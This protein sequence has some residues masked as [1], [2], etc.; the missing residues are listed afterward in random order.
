MGRNITPGT[1]WENAR[2]LVC[3]SM[4]GYALVDVA[5]QA[6]VL[7]KPESADT[8]LQYLQVKAWIAE[9]A[10]VQFPMQCVLDELD[11]HLGGDTFA[12]QMMNGQIR[13]S[14]GDT[15]ALFHWS[16]HVDVRFTQRKAQKGQ[17]AAR[18]QQ[19]LVQQTQATAARQSQVNAAR[20]RA[21]ADAVT[22]TSRQRRS[23]QRYTAAGGF[24]PPELMPVFRESRAQSVPEVLARQRLSDERCAFCDGPV[25][26]GLNWQEECAE[27]PNFRPAV[28]GN[29]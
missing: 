7:W 28:P 21:Q 12:T 25:H 16:G 4:F 20:N 3:A 17:Q 6:W 29:V 8:A 2:K 1:K 26:K 5:V 22:T 24:V 27:F 18:Q 11:E 9:V 15:T 19:A 13:N 23:G 14:T 10:G